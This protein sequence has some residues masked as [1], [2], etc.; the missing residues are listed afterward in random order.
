MPNKVEVCGLKV[1]KSDKI[2]APIF[3]DY[4]VSLECE[5]VENNQGTIV[6]KIVNVSADESVLT[7]G[8]ID[9]QKVGLI[10][11][12]PV[13]HTYYETGKEVGKTFQDGKKYI[14]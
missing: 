7:N 10:C 13:D 8:K 5:L 1:Q 4:P 11:Y 12:N 14:K 3:T 9:I 2:N 6:A